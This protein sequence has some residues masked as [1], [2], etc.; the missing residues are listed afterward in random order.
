[1]KKGVYWIWALKNARKLSE[2]EKISISAV[3]HK[4]IHNLKT[5]IENFRISEI[6]CDQLCNSRTSVEK[7]PIFED[8][9]EIFPYLENKSHN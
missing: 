1:M 9:L 2:V 6:N 8:F 4:M 5:S 7:M 3:S